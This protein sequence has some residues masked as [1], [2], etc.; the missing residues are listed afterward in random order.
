MKVNL[1]KIIVMVSGSKE[2]IITCKVDPCAI[3]AEG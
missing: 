2:E 3:A 1:K